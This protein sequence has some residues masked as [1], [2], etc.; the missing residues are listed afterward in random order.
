MAVVKTAV[1]A[2]SPGLQHNTLACY[3]R[4]AYT[5]AILRVMGDDVTDVVKHRQ[6]PSTSTPRGK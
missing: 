5:A 2:E 6:D 4:A 1:S 3:D